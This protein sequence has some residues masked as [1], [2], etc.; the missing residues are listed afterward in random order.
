MALLFVSLHCLSR[1]ISICLLCFQKCDYAQRV[2]WI[3]QWLLS[4]RFH[5]ILPVQLMHPPLLLSIYRCNC[6]DWIFYG[7]HYEYFG[8]FYPACTLQFLAKLQT[9]QRTTPT[10]IW[11][12]GV[13][14]LPLDQ[15]ANLHI[16]KL[17][18]LTYLFLA[19]WMTQLYRFFLISL[20]H[21]SYVLQHNEL[22]Y[23]R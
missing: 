6:L 9:V 19:M 4:K 20:S 15:A 7:K 2:Y 10:S 22:Q 21:S 16:R 12:K 8:Q 23:F 5:V 13:S 18:I 14:I 3:P 1:S 17:Q 11:C